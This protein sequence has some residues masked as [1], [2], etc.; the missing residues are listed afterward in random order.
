MNGELGMTNDEWDVS[1]TGSFLFI[2]SHSS[3]IH[4]KNQTETVWLQIHHFTFSIH[5]I[6]FQEEI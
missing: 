4:P 3:F 1:M 5:L 2:I 6:P